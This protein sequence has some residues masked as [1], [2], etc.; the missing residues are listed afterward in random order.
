MIIHIIYDHAFDENDFCYL[1]GIE[2]AKAVMEYLVRVMW[3]ICRSTDSLLIATELLHTLLMWSRGN[4][5]RK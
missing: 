4:K 5:V 1:L 3:H 2:P